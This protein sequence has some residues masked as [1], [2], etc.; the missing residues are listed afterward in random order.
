MNNQKLFLIGRSL[1]GAVSVQLAEKIQDQICGLILE[2]T[3]TSILEMVDYI[4]PAMS[5]FKHLIVRM[6]W[7]SLERIPRVRIPMLFVVGTADEI[8]PPAHS[9]KLF[10]AAV[11]APFKHMHQVTGGMHNDTWL[12]G[13]KDYIY[14]LKDFIDK[15]QEARAQ[16]LPSTANNN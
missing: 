15:A 1:G 12:K 16:A 6:Y 7:P 13:G 11:N 4:F 9:A 8:V 10:Q 3:F 5:N 14:A 2:N